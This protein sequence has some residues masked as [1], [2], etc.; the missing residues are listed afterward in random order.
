MSEII[1]GKRAAE[2]GSEEVKK[3]L[4]NRTAYLDVVV[5]GKWVEK[6]IGSIMREDVI[7]PVYEYK[8][9][10]CGYTANDNYLFCPWCGA[11]MRKGEKKC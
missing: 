1:D 6:S 2:L 5:K 10:Q 3:R 7:M 8:C 9:D 11:D 4:A